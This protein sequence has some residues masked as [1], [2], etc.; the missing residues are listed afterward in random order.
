M[1]PRERHHVGRRQIRI[2][3]RQHAGVKRVFAQAVVIAQVTQL[4]QRAGQP[5]D[6][7]FGKPGAAHEILVAKHRF[8]GTETAQQLQPPRQRGDEIGIALPHRRRC[9]VRK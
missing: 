1:R 7:G 2:P 4:H 9:V 3:Q 8:A 5:A 6:R